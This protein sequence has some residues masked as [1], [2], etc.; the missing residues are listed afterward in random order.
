MNK[1]N[2]QKP[3]PHIV[4]GAG[5]KADKAII[6]FRSKQVDGYEVHICQCEKEHEFGDNLPN[7]P[8]IV[9]QNEDI[10]GEYF[11][12]YFCKRESLRAMIRV[13][14]EID[15]KWVDELIGNMPIQEDATIQEAMRHIFKNTTPETQRQLQAYFTKGTDENEEKGEEVH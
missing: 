12:M 11:T 10:T 1:S 3:A 9:I 4:F 15:D 2:N 8:E 6:G 14:Q 7:L 5:N 13:L